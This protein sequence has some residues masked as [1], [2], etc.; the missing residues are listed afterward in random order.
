MNTTKK[1]ITLSLAATFAFGLVSCNKG[2]EDEPKPTASPSAS[3]SSSP[4]TSPSSSPLPT[5]PIEEAE[6]APADTAESELQK[7][8]EAFPDVEDGPDKEKIQLAL[9]NATR[10]INAIYDNGYLASGSWVKDGADAQKLYEL[11]GHNWSDD[12]RA[13]LDLIIHDYKNGVDA[14][15]KET[16]ESDLLRH[17]FFLSNTT[18]QPSDK[19]SVGGVGA[20]SCLTDQISLADMFF[21]KYDNGNILVETKFT[22][23]VETKKDG[24]SGTIPID[25]TIW[26]EM[27]ENPYPDVENLRYS[28]IVQDL[29]GGWKSHGWTAQD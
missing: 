24:K 8:Q 28:Y 21:T 23:N 25:Y 12:Y 13:K 5:G 1:L 10:Y 27:T 15:T 16:A 2:S 18:L 7:A 3:P 26:L 17:F 20:P 9:F 11:Q 6:Q 29:G 14:E 4:S 19:C 22:L